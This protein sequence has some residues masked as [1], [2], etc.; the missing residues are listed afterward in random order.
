MKLVFTCSNKT[1]EWNAKYERMC[2]IKGKKMDFCSKKMPHE[3][4][5]AKEKIYTQ[6]TNR[7]FRFPQPRNTKQTYSAFDNS[8]AQHLQ[9][10][11]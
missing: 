8:V 3:N 10:S 1:N 6:H 7:K 4:E 9:T 5:T 11:N 2:S